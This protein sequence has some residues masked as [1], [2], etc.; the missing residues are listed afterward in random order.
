MAEPTYTIFVRVPMPRGDFVDP[1]PVNWDSIKDEALWKILS[2]AAKKQ[3]DW[4]EVADRFE[5]P[6][7]FLLQQ[8]AYLTERHASQVRAQVRKATAAVRGS[9]PSPVPGGDSAGPGHQRAHSALSIRRDSP[10]PRNEAGSG[11]GTPLN[12]SIRPIVTRNTSTNTTVL[13]DMAGGSASPRPGAGLAS[14]TGE[15]RRLSSL[16]MSS[17]PTRSPERVALQEP[18]PDERSPSPGPADD[19][20][21]TSSEDE[22][23]P[24]QSRI[25]RRPPRFQQPDGQYGDDDGDESEPAFQPYTSPSNQTSAQDLGSTLRGEG[26]SSSKRHHRPH[27]K[28]AIHQSHTSDSSASSAAMVQRPEKSDKSAE[29][30]TPGPL[31]PRRTAELAGRSPGTNSKGYSREGSDGTP[32]MGSSYSDLDGLPKDASFPRDLAGLGYFVND[33]DEIRSIKNPD[34]YFKFFSSKNSRFNERQRFHFHMALEDIVHDRLEKEG[35]EKFQLMPG[36]KKQTPIFLTPNIAKTARIVIVL[37][38]HTQNLGWI[39]GRIMNGSGG[40]TKGSMVSVVQ[41]LATQTASPDDPGPPCIILANMG[42]RYWWP[43]EERALTIEAAG[44]IPLP[45]M[46]HTGRRIIKELNEIPGS[47][48]PL[49]HMA[50]VFNKVLEENKSAKVDII[51]IGQSCEVALEFFENEKNWSQWGHRLGGMLFMGTVFPA[52]GL[53][54]AEFKEFLA[55]RTRGYLISEEPLNTPLA[56]P[57]G[58]PS[59]LIEPLGCPCFS[60]GEQ[61]YIEMIFIQALEPALDYLQ[62]VALSPD[63]V[64]PDMPVAER[65]PTDITDEQWSEM[66]EEKKPEVTTPDPAMLK[67]QIKQMRRWEKFRKTGIAPDSD[68]DED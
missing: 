65:R 21:P 39:A 47:E 20:S 61:E 49:A 3:I 15:R 31:S 29:Q 22:S 62:E 17:V 53:T 41:A 2:G 35:L 52:D 5:V 16:P 56:M 37:G 60:S 55:K 24:A 4:D 44:D 67:D 9:V 45:S 6:V 26:P 48:T 27:G 28:V 10:M 66:P 1:P 32:S 33:Q 59:L 51:A 50:T 64:N 13:R 57:G 14:R 54:N 34:C 7:D 25:I 18:S 68:S 36:N 23:M 46:V 63:F 42:Q 43:E 40:I 11:T 8:V 30:R 12:A 58:N 19:S 38:E